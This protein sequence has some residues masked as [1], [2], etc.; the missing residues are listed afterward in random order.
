MKSIT[1]LLMKL[2][3]KAYG[4]E[5]LMTLKEFNKGAKDYLDNHVESDSPFGKWAN[6]NFK[7]FL[8]KAQDFAQENNEK[9]ATLFRDGKNGEAYDMI[10]NG[11]ARDL[12]L[13]MQSR[14]VPS[15]I[16]KAT[17][18]LSG[19]GE[20]LDEESVEGIAN[21]VSDEVSSKMSKPPLS[22]H[23]KDNNLS[24]D[25]KPANER[26]KDHGFNSEGTDNELNSLDF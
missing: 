11:V 2:F 3:K 23:E 9:L 14:E 4:E 26:V 6:D 10:H 25:E 24:F 13:D 12:G 5:G 20:A 19:V 8:D 1:E 21:L 16:G 7:E 22:K 18:G 17:S 15:N